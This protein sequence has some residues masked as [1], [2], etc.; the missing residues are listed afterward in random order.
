MK[1]NLL[2][3]IFLIS[4]LTSYAQIYLISENSRG[5]TISPNGIKGAFPV[6]S[7][8]T[9]TSM[10][11]QAL[12]SV[13]SGTKNTGIGYRALSFTSSASQLTAIG[14]AALSSNNTGALNSALGSDALSYNK[15]GNDNL[16]LG[17]A[18]LSYNVS[19]SRNIAIGSAT[20]REQ[21]YDGGNNSNNIAI[22]NGALLFNNPTDAS[23]GRYNL[24]IGN[25]VLKAN[26]TGSRN[27]GFVQ[28]ALHELVTGDDNIGMGYL[29]LQN[30]TAG[31]RNIA[32]GE[33]ALNMS[34]GSGNIAIG[35][36]AGL[37]ETGSNKLYISNLDS[38]Y[39]SPLIGG[40]F[41]AKK[42]S[43][44]RDIISTTYPND[45][46]NR[47]ET[48]QVEGDA[49]K[50]VGNGSWIFPSDRRL[51]KNI[52]A[53]NSQEMLEKVLLMQGVNYEMKDENQ[54]GIQYGFIAQDLQKIFP[55]KIKENKVGYLSADYGSYDPMIVESIKAL[56]SQLN[57][58]KTEKGSLET[59]FFQLNKDIDLLI[60]EVDTLEKGKLSSPKKPALSDK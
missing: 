31:S 8:I 33:K 17:T 52:L 58:L 46:N 9:N 19:L 13:T 39:D 14:N 40:D 47:S 43:I 11:S 45:F 59:T 51:K 38:D 22:G 20:L 35:Y 34:M 18:A 12:S 27:I 24:A 21:N 30:N 41:E 6:A 16:A 29:A 26:T 23:N 48:L 54:R 37:N 42:V 44:G 3:L 28:W 5:F 25:E 2:L 53:L 57:K 60:A 49:F 56:N 7:D 55:S 50:T 32:I 1:K 15:T 10:G 4:G 36:Q